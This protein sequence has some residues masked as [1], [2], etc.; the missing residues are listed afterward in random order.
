[1]SGL[2]DKINKFS[3]ICADDDELIQTL[4]RRLLNDRVR[5]LRIFTNGDDAIDGFRLEPADLLILDVSMPG[6]TG[7]E[8]CRE[9][10][11]DEHTVYVPVIIVSS[12]DTES[13]IVDGLTAGADD[14]IVKPLHAPEL[15]AKIYAILKKREVTLN[16]HNSITIGCH[17]SGKYEI[18]RKLG[19]GGVSEV[20]YARQLYKEPG[21]F[22]ALKIF[23]P[24]LEKRNDKES[25]SLFLREAYSL[26]KL[27]HPNIMKLYDFG[28]SH[29]YYFLA[30]EFLDGQTLEDIIKNT[31]P[32]PINEA[33]VIGYEVLKALHYLTKHN[34]IHYDIKPLNIMV[35]ASGDVKL[36]DFS[37]ARHIKDESSSSDN[38][39]WC[40]PQYTAPEII[41]NN[42]N[43]DIKADIFSLGVTMYYILTDIEPYKGTNPYQIISDR[44]ISTPKLLHEINPNISLNLSQLIHEMM[45]IAKVSRPGINEVMQ[46]FE[47]ILARLN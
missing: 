5:K 26:S 30:T 23:E 32:F 15:L 35:V 44:F 9:I 11:S 28:K 36:I 19:K 12:M 29:N 21:A 3:I 38:F 46:K 4:Y 1:M 42:Q 45:T 14:Y 27:D 8:I 40:S 13:A 24:S 37:L 25:M 7:L 43:I 47:E 10:R 17:F 34:L 6:K 2:T 20:F 22:V 18:L 31:G 41:E 33:M 16:D 39:L